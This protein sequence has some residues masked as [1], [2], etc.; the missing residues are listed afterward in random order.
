MFGSYGSRRE[1]E[2]EDEKNKGKREIFWGHGRV[3]RG[4]KKAIRK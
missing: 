4:K 2:M 1:N 3:K